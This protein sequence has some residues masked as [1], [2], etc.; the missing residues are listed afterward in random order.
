MAAP[1]AFS[2][3]QSSQPEGVTAPSV[4]AEARETPV[5]GENV[6]SV[7]QRKVPGWRGCVLDPR[8]AVGGCGKGIA[9]VMDEVGGTGGGRFHPLRG[10][11]EGD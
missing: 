5:A 4:H 1:G 11:P 9:R 6:I 10:W 3:C 2:G 8:S 7:G